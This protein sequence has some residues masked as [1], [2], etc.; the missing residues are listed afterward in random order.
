MSERKTTFRWPTTAD[1]VEMRPG[2]RARWLRDEILWWIGAYA[3]IWFAIQ[4]VVVVLA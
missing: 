3:T 2:A 4:V 1:L